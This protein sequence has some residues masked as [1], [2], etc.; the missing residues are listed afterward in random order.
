MNFS[1]IIIICGLIALAGAANGVMDTLSFHFPAQRIIPQHSQFWNPEF[2][3]RNKYAEV[4][5]GELAQPLMPRFTGST[6]VFS[7]LT[8]GWHLMKFLYQGLIRGAIVVMASWAFAL[9]WRRIYRIAFWC[10]VW[11]SLA[12]IQAAGFHFTYSFIF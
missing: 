6:T 1:R 4:S 2:S 3:W 5:P 12:G 8:D 9:A 10:G 7:F 11:I